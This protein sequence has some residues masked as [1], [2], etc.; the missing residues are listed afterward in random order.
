MSIRRA[1]LHSSQWL[2]ALLFCFGFSCVHLRGLA[3]AGQEVSRPQPSKAALPPDDLSQSKATIKVHTDTAPTKR[4]IEF[5]I[6]ERQRMVR[7]HLE[8]ILASAYRLEPAEH[9]IIT[10]V[11]T[12]SILW[13]ID[14]DRAHLVLSN[15]SDRLYA[16]PRATPAVKKSEGTQSEY[17][18]LRLWVLRKLARI[19]PALISEMLSKETKPGESATVA[20]DWTEEGRAVLAAAFEQIDRNPSLAGRLA[21]QSLSLGLADLPGFLRKLSLNDMRVAEQQARILIGQLRESSASPFFLL[22][23]Q[24]FVL[25][26]GTSIGLRDAYFEALNNRLQRSAGIEAPIADLQDTLQAARAAAR[27]SAAAP[28]WQPVFN[29]IVAEL[30]QTFM[31]RSQ[32]VPAPASRISVDVPDFTAS[33]GDTT[34]IAEGAAK[35]RAINDP[36]SEMSNIA[37]WRRLRR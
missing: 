3:C 35:A 29:G 26:K 18:R 34:E 5:S 28:K 24:S 21:Q 33:E 23:L 31:S 8:S 10:E 13:E 9:R 16:L 32:A 1:L 2:L 12:A 37:G 6:D 11:E 22:N 14:R 17:D 4:N 15:V 25:T 20:T 19:D 27:I 30:E 36:D 7:S